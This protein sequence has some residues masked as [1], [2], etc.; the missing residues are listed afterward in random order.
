DEVQASHGATV[1][2]LD[3]AAQHYLQTRGVPA[4]LARQMLIESFVLS[5]FEQVQQQ[6]LLEQLQQVYRGPEV[7]ELDAL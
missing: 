7:A 3:E 4:A 2:C 1:G 6:D 5:A